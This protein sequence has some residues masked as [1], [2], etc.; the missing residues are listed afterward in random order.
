MP[1]AC[2]AN[3]GVQTLLVPFSRGGLARGCISW[4]PCVQ[5]MFS[6]SSALA[7]LLGRSGI[8]HLREPV[9]HREQS[10]WSQGSG[11]SS[12]PEDALVAMASLE[13]RRASPRSGGG[14]GSSQILA[15]CSGVNIARLAGGRTLT[16][17]ALAGPSRAPAPPAIAAS[18]TPPWGQWH[19]RQLPARGPPHGPALAGGG[20][21]H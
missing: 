5:P 11:D 15:A 2:R 1:G 10:W 16:Q 8:R 9:A 17:W 19:C 18:A 13:A 20:R 7:R 12:S 3:P 4:A 6:A 21:G 14:A